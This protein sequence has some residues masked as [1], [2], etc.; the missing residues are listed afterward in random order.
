MA[1]VTLLVSCAP[2]TIITDPATKAQIAQRIAD[3]QSWLPSIP[4]VVTVQ[5]RQALEF[6]YAYMPF[7]DV[8]DYDAELFLTNVQATLK[9]RDEMKWRI[10]ENLFLHF[11]LPVRVNNETLDTSRGDFYAELADRVANLSMADA[12]LEVNH[13]CHEKVIY[14]PSDSRTSSPSA[15][16]RNAE[17]RCGEE[18]TFTVAALRS[19]GIPARQ[20]YVPRWA[21]TDDNHAWVEAWADGRWYYLGACE[22]EAVLNHG[23]FDAPARRSLL[24]HTKAFGAYQGAEQTL[25][26]TDSY[27]EIN[28]TDNYAPEVAEVMVTVFD[29]DGKPVE[30]ADVEFTIYNYAEFYP[31][32]RTKTDVRGQAQLMAGLG[33]MVVWAYKGDSFGFEEVRLGQDQGVEIKL[34]NAAAAARDLNIVPPV[35]ASV[36]LEISTDARNQN[37]TRLAIEDSIRNSY[38]A[39]FMTELQ[40]KELAAKLELDSQR[41]WPLMRESR[42]N[43]G[44]I[45]EFLESTPVDQLPVAMDLLEVISKK[46]LHDTPSSVLTDHLRSAFEYRD[47]EFFIPYILNPRVD[48][49]L[50]TPYRARLSAIGGCGTVEEI[51]STTKTIQPI[52]GLNPAALAI[53][54]LG[55]Q[56]LGR[57]DTPALERY[58][59]A[60]LRSKGVAA[61]HEPISAKLQYYDP[62]TKSWIDINAQTASI[63]GALDLRYKPASKNDDPKYYT[64][65]TI[66]RKEGTSFRTLALE[67]Q[68]AGVDMGAGVAYSAL[69]AR[70]LFLEVGSYRL[71]SGTRMADG[72]VL[73]RVDFF[74]IVPDKT[75]TLDLVLRRDAGSVSVI[76]SMNPESKFVNPTTGKVQTIMDITGRGYFI[77]G[78][79]AANQEPT[80]HAIRDLALMK[81]ELEAWGRGMVLV[82]PDQANYEKFNASAFDPLPSTATLGYD[83]QG[84]TLE[85]IRSMMELEN[86]NNLPIFVIAD[87]FGRVVFLS[88]GYTIGLGEQLVKVIERL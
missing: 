55:V 61:R 23:W 31:A 85:M 72:S 53:T 26:I 33:T 84:Q 8:A 36:N 63:K 35:D 14:T 16:V 51:L 29:A 5:E 64:H 73:S 10:P 65:F 58:T 87:T 12:I 52:D 7:G 45:R 39:T 70:P 38:T 32:V 11:V 88:Q 83:N 34:D 30:G 49:E 27:T 20:I 59:I 62:T 57:A 4:E 6:L 86:V 68:V 1:A 21:H 76:G 42:G 15:L 37:A 48:D 18:S 81:K 24:M 17:G 82:F 2:K 3:R 19:V 47:R 22:P 43:H 9:A 80:N 40:S 75:T 74:E 71:T 28:A 56:K 79:V 78:L 66:A 77:L 50:L 60:L 67:S 25:Q 41:L 54:P 44:Q 13:W 69:F 46:D